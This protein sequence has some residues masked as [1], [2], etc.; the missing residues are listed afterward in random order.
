[1]AHQYRSKVHHINRYSLKSEISAQSKIIDVL[2]ENV[3]EAVLEGLFFR[4]ENRVLNGFCEM[5]SIS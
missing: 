5:T 1:M 3:R 4:G 2:C